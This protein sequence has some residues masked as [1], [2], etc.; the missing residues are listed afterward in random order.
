MELVAVF[1]KFSKPVST[2]LRSV[3]GLRVFPFFIVFTE[4]SIHRQDTT[5]MKFSLINAT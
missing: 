2:V 1:Q 5:S 3:K 4:S